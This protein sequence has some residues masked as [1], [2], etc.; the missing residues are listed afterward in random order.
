MVSLDTMVIIDVKTLMAILVVMTTF[1]MIAVMV[2]VA[3]T[4]MGHRLQDGKKV[5]EMSLFRC[6]STSIPHKFPPY[7]PPSLPP[8]LPTSVTLRSI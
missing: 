1:S 6:V 7:L 5:N 4:Y 2:T 3:A 8:S